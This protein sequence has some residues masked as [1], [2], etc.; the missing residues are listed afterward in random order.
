[1]NLGAVDNGQYFLHEK[2]KQ[3]ELLCCKNEKEL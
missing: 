1:M 3:A 2:N